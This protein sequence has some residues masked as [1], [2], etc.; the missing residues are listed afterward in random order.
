VERR[1]RFREER[2]LLV[3]IRK[4]RRRER[5]GFRVML[6]VWRHPITVSRYSAAVRGR[7]SAFCVSETCQPS[8]LPGGGCSIVSHLNLTVSLL[9]QVKKDRSARDGRPG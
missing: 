8:L 1:A 3:A 9:R 7:E 5:E 2:I 6:A 4:Q